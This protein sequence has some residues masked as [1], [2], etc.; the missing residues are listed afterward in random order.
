[1]RI[2]ASHPKAFGVTMEELTGLVTLIRNLLEFPG[3]LRLC[4]NISSGKSKYGSE[5][6]GA[7]AM[8]TFDF[9]AVFRSIPGPPILDDDPLKDYFATSRQTRKMTDEASQELCALV[10]IFVKALQFSLRTEEDPWQFLSLF[11]GLKY[12]YVGTPQPLQI[13]G[14]SRKH[15]LATRSQNPRASNE[16]GRFPHDV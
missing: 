9:V 2:V 11:R 7:P 8:A 4:R 14:R 5:N 13:L 10:V 1:M 12:D 6:D 15:R 16:A 3:I